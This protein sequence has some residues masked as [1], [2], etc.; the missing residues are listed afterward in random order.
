M[1]TTAITK[2]F[3]LFNRRNGL[4][5]QIISICI[6]LS[7]LL[8]S[9]VSQTPVNLSPSTVPMQANTSSPTQTQS[10]TATATITSTSTTKPTASHTPTVTPSFTP[11]PSATPS[12]SA[13]LDATQQAEEALRQKQVIETWINELN[14]YYKSIE[15][16]ES[17]LSNDPAFVAR[18]AATLS[19]DGIRTL[20]IDQLGTGTYPAFLY[21]QVERIGVVCENNIPC[22]KILALDVAKAAINY[23]LYI[24]I[25]STLSAKNADETVRAALDREKGSLTSETSLPDALKQSLHTY[26]SEITDHFNRDFWAS[27][28][29][30]LRLTE[31]E[32]ESL[33]QAIIDQLRVDLEQLTL[34]PKVKFSEYTFS[35]RL[36]KLLDKNGSPIFFPPPPPPPAV[37]KDARAQ[38]FRQ[39]GTLGTWKAYMKT[40]DGAYGI[41]VIPG[42][43]KFLLDLLSNRVLPR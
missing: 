21:D 19:T 31:E 40:R 38:Y 25:E 26:A 15:P 24:A 6:A 39:Q 35:Y 10:P 13:T 16:V 30:A 37:S 43:Q 33:T 3:R 5:N 32:Q 17:Y 9:C 12:P 22:Q 14:A 4:T 41:Y 42:T 2:S 23:H 20:A 1:A 11:L 29:N 36:L 7:I 27:I 28:A 18:Q 8:S 34:A